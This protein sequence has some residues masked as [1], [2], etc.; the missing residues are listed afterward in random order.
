MSDVIYCADCEKRLSPDEI[1]DPHVCANGDVI[2][3]RCYE[4]SFD[5]PCARC[6]EMME[7]YCAEDPGRFISV[8]DFHSL[9]HG[10]PEGVYL[11]LTHPLFD[12]DHNLIASALSQVASEPAG[13][14][15]HHICPNCSVYY[16]EKTSEHHS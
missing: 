6:G 14:D 9:V 3:Q 2:C 5:T 15:F 13:E 1:E 11:I 7:F 16:Q 8:D 12:Q 10:V 4:S